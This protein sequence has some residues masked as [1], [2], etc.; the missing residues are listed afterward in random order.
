MIDIALILS[1]VGGLL[2]VVAM[3]QPLAVAL[4]VSPAVLL[5][6]IG[7]AI[8]AFSTLLAPALSARGYGHIARLFAE[9]P[10]GSETL[11]DVFLPPLVFEAAIASDVRRMAEDAAPILVL[12]VVAT[13][14]TSAAI[15]FALWPFAGVPLVVCLLLGATVAT[16][17]PAAVLS[18]FRDVGAPARLTRLVEGEALLND[19]AAISL[20]AVLLGMIVSGRAAD[21]AQGAVE[22]ATSFFG[23]ALLGLVAG[24][25][26]LQAIPLT[27]D[28]RLAETTLTIALAY[29]VF[30]AAERVLHV[31]GVVAVLTSGLTVNAFGRARINPYNWDFLRDLWDQIAFWAR[32][33]IFVLASILAPKLLV[34]VEWHDLLLCVILIVTALTVRLLILFVLLPPLSLARLTQPI[35]TAYKLAIAWGGLRGALTL[36]LALAVTENQAVPPQVQRFVA[37]LA[38]GLVLFT[39]L[40]N[41]TT[42]RA[43]IKLLGLDRLSPIDQVLRDQVLASTYAEMGETVREIATAHD[44]SPNALEKVIRPYEDWI[45]AANMRDAEHTE[46]LEHDRLTIGLVALANQERVLV[47]RTLAQ[48]SASPDTVQVLLSNA[49]RL[50][51]AARNDGRIGYKRAIEAG[52]AFSASQ[53]FA[54][55]VY[56][57]LGVTRLLADRLG[58]RYEMLLVTRLLVQE[59]LPFNDARLRGLFGERL[60]DVLA[61]V[62]QARLSYT[63]ERLDALRRQYPRYAA[64]LETRFLRQSA[65]RQEEGRYQTLFDEGMIAPEVYADLQRGLAEAQTTEQRPRFDLGL[66]TRKLI[67]RLDLFSNLD[68]QQLDRVLKLLRAALHRSGRADCAQGRARRCSL[69]H[70][71][72]GGRGHLPRQAHA[73]R[74]G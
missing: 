22:F 43:V 4:K 50:I 57:R 74:L 45:K 41:G 30:V 55:L 73:A 35:S 28:D 64:A 6:V 36:V 23:G 49:E 3:S 62:L 51:E 67:G 46:L 44:L 7:V 59:L 19:A 16:T 69:F 5:A 24:R 63:A 17:D 54:Y 13:L 42:L 53:R 72:R 71:F 20:F 68:D 66:D 8:G 26:L 29:L 10:I 58:E 31:S 61:K 32:S 14:L 48:R 1:V 27:R 34:H 37:V 21:A 38:T 39:L 2:V 70:C 11:I 52:L 60:A 12:A 40:V 56:R 33:L 47:L 9:F 15:G 25:A 65:L 18:V